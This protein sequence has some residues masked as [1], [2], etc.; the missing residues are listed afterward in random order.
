MERRTGKLP[1][2]KEGGGARSGF[3]SKFQ[4]LARPFLTWG[5]PIQKRR[6]KEGI[7]TRTRESLELVLQRE[8][9][10]RGWKT[11]SMRNEYLF[12]PRKHVGKSNS[13][14]SKCQ[15]LSL[16][17]L[18]KD[19]W[20]HSA[21]PHHTRPLISHLSIEHRTHPSRSILHHYRAH[22][23][24]FCLLD[25]S[26]VASNMTVISV[27]ERKKEKKKWVKEAGRAMAAMISVTG[28]N[29][30]AVSNR[31]RWW[32]WWCWQWLMI[33]FLPLLSSPLLHSFDPLQ[34]R[35]NN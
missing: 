12:L 15:H 35:R 24:S 7:L 16:L 5:T 28:K 34:Y 29:R 27:W 3:L 19:L 31:R 11:G 33:F 32:Q 17:R 30:A 10:R 2:K 1:K 21:P 26:F 22:Y 25:T 18:P 14:F 8:E 20:C 13:T 9:R 23:S 6:K 4:I